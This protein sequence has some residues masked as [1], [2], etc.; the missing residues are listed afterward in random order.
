[1]SMVMRSIGTKKERAMIID[2]D[3][4]EIYSYNGCAAVDIDWKTAIDNTK[5]DLDCTVLLAEA[6]IVISQMGW[7]ILGV[8]DETPEG[9]ASIYVRTYEEY[10]DDPN[11]W[12]SEGV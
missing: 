4:G 9:S 6:M 10:R 5:S 3:M 12:A 1:M 2:G 8:E 7:T 11:P